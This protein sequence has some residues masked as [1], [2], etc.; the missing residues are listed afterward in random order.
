VTELNR[1]KFEKGRDVV[2]EMPI[3]GD[4]P[5][6]RPYVPPETWSHRLRRW[7]LSDYFGWTIMLIALLLLLRLIGVL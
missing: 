3:S 4:K 1:E 2:R 7:G 6:D 5:W